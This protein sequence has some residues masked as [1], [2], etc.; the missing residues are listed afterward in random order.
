MLGATIFIRYSHKGRLIPLALLKNY[1][2]L[3]RFPMQRKQNINSRDPREALNLPHNFS[4]STHLLNDRESLSTHADKFIDAEGS[5]PALHMHKS[6]T[7]MQPTFQSQR[8]SRNQFDRMNAGSSAANS[9]MQASG[10]LHGQQYNNLESRGPGLMK[11]PFLSDQTSALNHQNHEKMNPFLPQFRPPLDV[12]D[13]FPQS[14]MPPHSITHLSSHGYPMQYPGGSINMGPPNS[15]HLPS[16]I[17]NILSNLHPQ[18]GVRPPPLPLGPRPTSQMMLNPQNSGSVIPNQQPAFSGLINSLMSQGFISLANQTPVQGSLGLEFDA[19]LL[20]VRHES[21]ISGFYADLPRQCKTC[22][23]R[24]KCQEEHSTH[25]DWHVN[26]N[27]TSK[28][29]KQ[30]PSRKWFVSASMWLTGAEA[31]GTDAVPSFLTSEVV[32]EKKDDEELAVPADEDQSE[33]ALCGERFDDFFSD[34]TEEWMYK[35]AVYLNAPHGSITGTDRSHLGPIVHAK[36]RSESSSA[37][38][39]DVKQV[40]GGHI[41]EGSQRKRLRT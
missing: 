27:R 15:A 20:K 3:L 2:L 17:N 28:S 4:Q 13:N 22:G 24:F 32:L 18:M 12:R 36:C 19:D 37:P 6:N 10:S 14:S 1:T 41:E 8:Q 11:Q 34:E 5:W 30:K 25:M 16:Q 38:P 31:L 9:E 23:L 29:R 7:S 35:G 26:R 40:E 33:C 21:A 39:E